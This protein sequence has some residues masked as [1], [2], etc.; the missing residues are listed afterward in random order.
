MM[1]C[2]VTV[3]GGGSDAPDPVA[4]L[5]EAGAEVDARNHEDETPLA[6]AVR[7][8]KKAASRALLEGGAALSEEIAAALAATLGWLRLAMGVLLAALLVGA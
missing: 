3:R 4:R 6:V 5:L 7:R 2:I 1:G 8:D